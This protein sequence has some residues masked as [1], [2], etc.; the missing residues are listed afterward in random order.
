MSLELNKVALDNMSKSVFLGS[1]SRDLKDVRAV[2]RQF[3]PTLGCKLI[4]FEDPKFKKNSRKHVH[5]MCLDNVLD[6]NIYLLIID[7]A[8]GEKYKGIRKKFKALSVTW[9]EVGSALN[10]NK[11]IC[12]FVRRE[13]WIEKGTWALNKKDGIKIKPC[14]AKD[15]KVFKFIEYI[16]KMSKGNW[17]EPF[18]DIEDLKEKVKSRLLFMIAEG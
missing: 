7:Q 2:L 9:A 15:I 17:I 18:D 4:C 1:T 16:V 10:K 6:C 13:V 5:D 8:F 12:V 3:I 14:Y 11:K